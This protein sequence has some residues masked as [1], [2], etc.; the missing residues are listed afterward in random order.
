MHAMRMSGSSPA[1]A[2]CSSA[3][4]PTTVWWRSTWLSTE[5]SE[6]LVSS[7][8]AASSTASLMARPREPGLSGHSASM[9]AAV[10]RRRRRAGDDRGPVRLHE[11]PAVRLLVV[12]R[13][14]HVDLDLEAEQ[15][16]GDRQG[17][18]PLAGA[19]L[20]GEALDAL[21]LVVEGLGDRGVGLVAP[22]RAHALVLVV[23][24]RRGV[25]DLLQPPCP[26]ERAGAVEAIRLANRVRDLH[27][28]VAADLL[29]D[30]RHREQ[31][32]QVGGPQGLHGSRVEGRR[33]RDGK[34]GHDVVPGPRDPVL[35]QHELR[36][37]VRH[38]GPP[39]QR[40]GFG[41]C[42][43]GSIACGGY[44]SGGRPGKASPRSTAV[45]SGR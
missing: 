44:P 31:R 36:P 30:D 35:V 39:G 19:G 10:L 42:A 27:L 21:L 9:L 34:V 12:A 7:R 25:E 37:V 20:R 18:P 17:R 14:D 15:R 2:S 6:Y 23:D 33:G 5:P 4:R 43:P 8:V 1:S 13:P 3:S 32:G 22:T 41:S 11:H 29:G 28:P 45:A 38:V 24:V 26:V 40:L 16:S